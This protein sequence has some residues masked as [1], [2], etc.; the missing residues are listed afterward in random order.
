MILSID[1][2]ERRI[3]CMTMA[4]VHLH[5]GL[6]NKPTVCARAWR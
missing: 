5:R 4:I 2:E 6:P 3:G 1:C